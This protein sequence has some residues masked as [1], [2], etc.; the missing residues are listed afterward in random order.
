MQ[1]DNNIWKV[2]KYLESIKQVDE[3]FDYYIDRD[4]QTGCPTMV[5]W[6]T[7]TMWAD[8]ELY[9]A[10]LHLDFMKR[11]MNSYNWPYVSI[12]VMDANGS[13]RVATE[14]IACTERHEAYVAGVK[15]ALDMTPHRT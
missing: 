6:Q 4:Q 7:G 10:G 1:S 15:S 14:G 13:P 3:Y 5:I 12:V 11:K 9:G 8:F 2:E